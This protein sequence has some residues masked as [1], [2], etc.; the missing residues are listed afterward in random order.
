MTH[1]L[2]LSEVKIQFSRLIEAVVSQDDEIIITRNGKPVAVLVNASDFESWKETQQ[3]KA[4]PELMEEIRKGLKALQGKRV[5]KYTNL[6]E[7]FGPTI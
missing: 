4:D 6:D 1:I 3:I 5:H 7:L 2:P